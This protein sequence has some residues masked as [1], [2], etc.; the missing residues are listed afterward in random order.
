MVYSDW[1]A[2]LAGQ[3]HL[4]HTFHKSKLRTGCATRRLWVPWVASRPSSSCISPGRVP[5]PHHVPPNT[6]SGQ[7]ES[8]GPR[9]SYKSAHVC[10]QCLQSFDHYHSSV[11]FGPSGLGF[12]PT[13]FSG[14][15]GHFYREFI[16]SLIWVSFS[17]QRLFGLPT[18]PRSFFSKLS[19]DS[20]GVTSIFKVFSLSVPV[21]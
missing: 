14:S 9:Y 4:I 6:S 13:P 15:P 12:H 1:T 2:G 18:L 16:L 11:T 8:W 20:L 7:S 5:V 17:R 19:T 3:A 10:V 21:E